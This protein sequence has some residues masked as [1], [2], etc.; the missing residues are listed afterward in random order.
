MQK[1][2]VYQKSTQKRGQPLGPQGVEIWKKL[3]CLPQVYQ[4]TV[5]CGKYPAFSLVLGVFQNFENCAGDLYSPEPT[6]AG[7]VTVQPVTWE[8]CAYTA[9]YI[10]KKLNGPQ[11]EFYTQFNIDPPFTLCSRKPG[12]G[13]QYYDDHPDLYDHDFIHVSTSTGG[14]KFR[15]PRYYHKLFDVDY[16][17]KSAELRETRKRM[18]EYQKQLKMEKTDLSYLEYLAVEESSLNDRIKSLKREA[19]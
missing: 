17:E 13:R 16:P 9:R 5:S 6:L 10:T 14:K 7:F 12:I 11:G 2:L 8:C 4:M 1:F 18:A 19:N 3:G 15:P